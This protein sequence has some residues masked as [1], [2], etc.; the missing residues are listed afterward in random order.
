V[1]SLQNIPLTSAKADDGPDP[2]PAPTPPSVDTA[3]A[4]LSVRARVRAR[5]VEILD[6]DYLSGAAN[7]PAVALT[8]YVIRGTVPASW[9]YLWIAITVFTVAAFIVTIRGPRPWRAAAA[10]LTG[11]LQKRLAVHVFFT[12]AVGALWGGACLAFSPILP[13]GQMMFLTVI[14]LGCNAACVSALGPYLP[15]FFGYYFASLAPLAYAY[16]ERSEPDAYGLAL[17]VLLYMMTLAMNVRAHNRQVLAAF[18]LRAENEL[19]AERV[20]NANAATVAATQ[21]KWDTLAHLSHELRTPMNAI[22]GFSEMM[23]E[24][25][26]GPLGERYLTYSGNIHDSGRHTLYLIDTLLEVSRAEAGQ[27]SLTDSE[28]APRALVGE[29]LRMVEVAAAAKHLTLDRRFAETMPLISVDGA[30]LRQ[31]LLNLLTNAIK[32]TPEGGRVSVTVQMAGG[33]L[34]FA[35]A[36]TGVG[37][38]PEDLERCLEPF[39][40]LAN[41]LTSGVE[42]AGLGLP[43]ARRLVE[44]HGGSLRIASELGRGTTVTL[45]LPPERC[46]LPHLRSAG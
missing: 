10:R 21:S 36:D 11:S 20:V 27:L 28:V 18:R 31:A 39:V 33:G 5:Q 29:C 41:P 32:Y 22:L 12:V 46:L 1:S 43:L 24:Q 45:H 2:G 23:R 16:L 8:A 40:R 3:D 42:G 25:L 14:V 9:L 37:I 34:D 17:L 35:V 30:K 26:F 13:Q 4:S 7:I 15:A 19:L 44:L 6:G 38:A